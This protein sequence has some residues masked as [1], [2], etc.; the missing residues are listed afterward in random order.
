MAD[1][2]RRSLIRNQ[3]EPSRHLTRIM[4]IRV[5]P[6]AFRVWVMPVLLVFV[7][8]A[9]GGCS[10]TGRTEYRLQA[11]REAYGVI[12][13]RNVDPRWQAADYSIEI[14]P[15][16]RYFD[17]HDPDRPPMP[18]DDPASH[19]YM[20]LVDGM[21]GWKHW[22]DNGI[23]AELENPRWRDA[24]AEYVKVGKDG[25]VKLNID[26]ALQLAYIHS[27]SHQGQLETLYLSA[28]D[29]TTE[30]F[31]LDTQF[32]GEYGATY[33]NNRTLKTDQL[34]VGADPV[35]QAQRRF[36][37]A[38]EL[39]IGFANSFVVEFTDSSANFTSSLANFSFV[40]PLLRGAGRDVA[41]EQLTFAERALLAN[42]RA[43]HQYRQGFYTQIA[44]GE[45]GVGGP[46]RS[47]GGTVISG[48]GGQSGVS[49]YIGLLQQLQ[50]KRNTE[51]NL[52]LQE[53]TLARLAAFQ[54]IG[55]IDL[56]QVD[57]FR[58]S[59]EDER[60]NLLQ[61][62]NGLELALDY[63]KTGTLGLPPD[64][65]IELDDSLIRKFQ[66]VA[67]DATKVEDAIVELQDRVGKL[68]DDTGVEPIRRVLI[69]ASTLVKPIQSQLDDVIRLLMS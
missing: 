68:P 43:Y 61:S 11:D 54:D 30:R 36:A 60:A 58:Q 64:L 38:G 15:R 42:L 69:D 34:T 67:R 45:L 27:P 22:N 32:F 2:C 55:V 10:R 37:T 13:E 1:F 20:Q 25:A 52:S 23:R 33:D 14:D 26:S 65:P 28:L 50:W 9:A 19:Q 40:Q 16:S 3:V 39:L 5:W 49:G 51:D 17:P 66:L 7:V 56:V 8:I 44:I 12:A 21:K 53:R 59:I 57:Q 62:R 46:Q 63:Y 6:D 35:L 18:E 24:L 4:G 47:G 29:V 41:L 48:F 31:R